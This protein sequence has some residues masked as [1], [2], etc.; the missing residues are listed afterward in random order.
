MFLFGR[1]CRYEK[2][3]LKCRRCGL[4]KIVLPSFVRYGSLRLFGSGFL[5]SL[6]L[7]LHRET[8]LNSGHGWLQLLG[9]SVP[10]DVAVGMRCLL[11]ALLLNQV[12]SLRELDDVWMS[13]LAR[14]AFAAT[15]KHPAVLVMVG[16]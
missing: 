1:F 5:L 7:A 16:C 11:E 3:P 13:F 4:S 15:R 14:S 12:M 8:P 10:T 9:T 2:T 6:P